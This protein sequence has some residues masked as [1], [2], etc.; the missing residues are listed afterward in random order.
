MTATDFYKT[1]THITKSTEGEQRA[2][3][4]KPRP[5]DV[6]TVT[7]PKTGQT[8]LLAMLRKLALGKGHGD[9]DA[10]LAVTHTGEGDR[11][12]WLEHAKSV[13]NIYNDQPGA[14]RIYK[15]HLDQ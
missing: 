4:F 6:M 12:P 11:V 10:K 14:F 9:V 2:L 7:T 3:S 15:S 5:T 1:I 8:W 13:S